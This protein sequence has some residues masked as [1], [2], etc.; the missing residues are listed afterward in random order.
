MNKFSLVVKFL[1]YF[2][3]II[4]N[5]FLVDHIQ[6]YSQTTYNKCIKIP[7]FRIDYY[8]L[9][10]V[11]EGEMVYHIN[12]KKVILKKNDAIFLTPGTLRE[13][14]FDI[15]NVKYVSYNFHFIKNNEI[16]L[17]VFMPS[18]VTNEIHTLLSAF[19]FPTI[20]NNYYD[21][22]KCSSILNAIL[23]ELINLNKDIST[24][25]YIKTITRYIMTH[26][27][28]PLS[29]KDVCRIVNLSEEYC[30]YLFKKETGKTVVE[31]I[32]EKK[33]DYAKE[34]ICHR[35]MPLRDIS[36]YLGYR[37]YNYFSRIYK[38]KFLCTPKKTIAI[39]EK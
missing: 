14:D 21:Q 27:T 28:E 10:F 24:N 38:K 25:T 16:V 35:E 4:M 23:Y 32:N 30:A 31:Y 11:L 33:L 18:V 5:T 17:P 2:K 34:L 1:H 20:R 9:T 26:I 7:P 8:D 19:P 39:N 6:N 22:E 3:E 29:L 37:N 36:E 15:I 13:R 12:G